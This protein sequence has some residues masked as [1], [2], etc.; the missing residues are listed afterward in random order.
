MGANEEKTE[1]ETIDVEQKNQAPVF[2]IQ[3]KD[4][5]K[6]DLALKVTTTEEDGDATTK[7]YL[8]DPETGS[9]N[10]STQ[11]TSGEFKYGNLII[12]CV[13]P[14]DKALADGML[15]HEVISFGYTRTDGSARQHVV[16][17]G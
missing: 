11:L 6:L 7:V 9:D 8:C 12:V 4:H 2:G 3:H 1:V 15:M 17:G 10:S 13:K 16:K 5:N 14:N